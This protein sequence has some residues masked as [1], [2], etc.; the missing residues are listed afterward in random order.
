MDII[1]LNI[2]EKIN[3]VLT[4]TAEVK[5][6]RVQNYISFY[7]P[8]WSPYIIEINRIYILDTANLYVQWDICSITGSL[9]FASLTIWSAD[10]WFHNFWHFIIWRLLTL[11]LYKELK[12]ALNT[13]ISSED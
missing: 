13:F 1:Y 4:G 11:K 5:S 9:I 8:K 10:L 7:S 12:T 2:L 3:L 6:L